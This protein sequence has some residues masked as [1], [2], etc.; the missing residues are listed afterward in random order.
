M[1][2]STRGRY[3]MRLMIDIAINGGPRPI[4]L[5]EIAARQEISEKYLEQIISLLSKAGLVRGTR[6]VGGGYMLGKPAE[7]ITAGDILRALEGDLSFVEC[8][9][10]GRAGCERA[11]ECPTINLW[12]DMR[13]AVAQVVDNRTLASMAEG[14]L[15]SHCSELRC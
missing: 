15:Q 11:E 2:M 14:F 7:E 1:K 13:D 8:L 6:G 4:A 3:G 9:N 10:G 5:K 12:R